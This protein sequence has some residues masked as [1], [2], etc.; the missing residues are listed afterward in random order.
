MAIKMQGKSHVVF[1]QKKKAKKHNKWFGGEGYI[2][3]LDFDD[4]ITGIGI[5]PNTSKCIYQICMIF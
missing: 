5:C 4:D 1:L 3:Y 2:Y